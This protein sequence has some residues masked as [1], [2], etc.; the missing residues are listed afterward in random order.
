MNKDVIFP[1][2]KDSAKYIFLVPDLEKMG[3]HILN[4]KYKIKEK[5]TS[6]STYICSWV[7][8]KQKLGVPRNIVNDSVL[9]F[10]SKLNKDVQFPRNKNIQNISP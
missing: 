2:K 3:L 8:D 10:K 1:S 7:I 9:C 5:R 6:K 4:L